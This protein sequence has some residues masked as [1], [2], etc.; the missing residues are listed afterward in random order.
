MNELEYIK[1]TNLQKLR[2]ICD[3]IHDILP[4]ENCGIMIKEY[5]NLKRAATLLRDNLFEEVK[6]KTEN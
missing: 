4:G 1:A 2:T 3:I 5:S 6:L